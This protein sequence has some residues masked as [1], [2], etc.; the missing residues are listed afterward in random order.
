[1]E[2]LAR[3]K[4][5]WHHRFHGITW[6]GTDTTPFIYC[7]HRAPFDP[8][9]T[10]QWPP[11]PPRSLSIATRKLRVSDE[12]GSAIKRQ[13][14]TSCFACACKQSFTSFLTDRTKIHPLWWCTQDKHVV[15]VGG[16]VFYCRKNVKTS[17]IYNLQSDS[18]MQIFLPCFILTC[19]VLRLV[20]PVVFVL[21]LLISVCGVKVGVWACLTFVGRVEFILA[22]ED[23]S[24]LAGEGGHA[25]PA[26]SPGQAGGFLL[27]EGRA[28]LV[29]SHPDWVAS[30]EVQRLWKQ[31]F[32]L[33]CWSSGLN[34]WYSPSVKIIPNT[35]A[36]MH[37][38]GIQTLH[39]LNEINSR[40]EFS[41]S[42]VF[43]RL[44]LD[45]STSLFQQG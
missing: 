29:P 37:V 26:E 34:S 9:I 3:C 21:L 6:S 31:P 10:R 39:I 12:G 15:C 20:H 11:P 19:F 7:T 27:T 18:A 28:P 2:Q 40:W 8:T 4:I 33:R 13:W 42:P 24:A 22:V 38:H 17:G 16:C 36:S 14:P 43:P 5:R 41:C 45:S 32:S 25:E 1:M 30:T 44:S 23:A 35:S